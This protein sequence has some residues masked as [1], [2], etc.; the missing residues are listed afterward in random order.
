MNLAGSARRPN[1]SV[2]SAECR[3]SELSK[4]RVSEITQLRKEDV[5]REGGRWV[6]RIT[7]EAGTMK[8]GHYR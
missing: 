2:Q 6:I 8:A 1:L 4:V 7:P 3:L 5:R